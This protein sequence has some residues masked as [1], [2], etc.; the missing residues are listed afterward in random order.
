MEHSF[1]IEVAKEYGIL[2]AVI[3]RNFQYWIAKN[4]AN[5]KNF[6]D[7]R[8][9][10]YNSLNALNELFPYASQR[11]IRYALDNLV[12]KGVLIKGCHNEDKR[13]RTIWF[14]FA[15]NGKW[16]CQNCQIT[17]DKNDNCICQNCQMIANNIITNN[18]HTDN[19]HTNSKPLEGE[20][21]E[22][23]IF[24]S[25]KEAKEKEKGCAEKEKE[26]DVVLQPW[27]EYK[28]ERK[29]T[30]KSQRALKALKTKLINLSGDNLEVA[31]LIIEQ[32]MAN[33]YAGLFE[34]KETNNPVRS[35][36]PHN[37]N[38]NAFNDFYF[39]KYGTNFVWQSDTSSEIQ[40][41]AD[42]I[43]SKISESGNIVI[44]SEMPNHIK[45][46]LAKTWELG[47][48]WLNQHFTPKNI[49]KQFNE[50]YVYIKA[51]KKPTCGSKRSN[52]TGVSDEYLLKLQRDLV[53]GVQ[54]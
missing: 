6:M 50:I 21:Q 48:Q 19:K 29:Q 8:Y 36:H 54:P 24:D 9:W 27:L 23:T 25:E 39:A 7:G 18:K 13:D 28:K 30:Y 34:L 11:Q 22:K 44:P 53:G 5:R 17:F 10:T 42:A 35:N 52:P 45:A 37:A 15:D 14:A 33:N 32:S 46:F 20:P 31:R 2:E 16:I 4:I 47:D 38:D 43:S 40:R 12:E 49:N 1:D 26:W 41:L 51:G 3:I